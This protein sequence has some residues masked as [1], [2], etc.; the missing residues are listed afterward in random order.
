M[1]KSETRQSK[2]PKQENLNRRPIREFNAGLSKDGKY[3]LFRDTTL[4]VIP[5]NYL[6]AIRKSRLCPPTQ[7]SFPSDALQA[8]ETGEENDRSN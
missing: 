3:W 2:G 7:T 8:Q 5:V 1:G 6:A 4:W